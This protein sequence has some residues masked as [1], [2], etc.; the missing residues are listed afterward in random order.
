V[1]HVREPDGHTWRF[2]PGALVIAFAYTGGIAGQPEQWH[3]P[4]DLADWLRIHYPD[5]AHEVGDRELAD[6]LALRRAVTNALLAAVRGAAPAPD[7]VDII[8]LYAAIPDI[9]PALEGGTRQAGRGA[10][11]VGQA[12]SELARQAVELFAPR[13]RDRIRECAADDCGY[14]FYDESRSGNR[15]WCSMQRCGNRA[16]VRRFRAAATT[17]S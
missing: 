6:A 10:P 13:E 1:T 4:A 9:P 15:R 12:L 11:R 5:V 3:R 14:V 7:D 17:A 16:K 2:D 8:N